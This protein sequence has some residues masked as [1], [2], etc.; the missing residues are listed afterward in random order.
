MSGFR[1]FTDRL[2]VLRGGSVAGYRQ[3]PLVVWPSENPRVFKRISEHT[4]PAYYRMGEKS[5]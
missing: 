5:A 3:K 4:L 2:A 1:A